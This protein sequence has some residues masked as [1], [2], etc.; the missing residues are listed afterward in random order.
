FVTVTNQLTVGDPAD[1]ATDVGPLI[2]P[3]EVDRVAEWVNEAIAEGAQLLTGGKRISETLYQ[4]TVLLN[5]SEK[6]KVSTSEIF[7]PVVCIYSYTDREEAISRANALDVHFQAA[8][9]TKN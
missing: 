6:S 5:P 4:P 2:L 7:G 8:V 3:K 9:F 1:A